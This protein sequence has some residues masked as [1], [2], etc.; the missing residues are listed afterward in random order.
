MRF[1]AYNL[2][3]GVLFIGVLFLLGLGVHLWLQSSLP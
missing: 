3:T 2:A 1:W